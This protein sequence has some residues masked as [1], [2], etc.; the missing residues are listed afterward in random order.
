MTYYSEAVTPNVTHS[1]PPLTHT[2]CWKPDA[3]LTRTKTLN[4][5]A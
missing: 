5:T 1:Q 4:P 3:G 2:E